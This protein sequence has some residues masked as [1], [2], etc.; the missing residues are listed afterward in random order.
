MF[1][2]DHQAQ[3]ERQYYVLVSGTFESHSADKTDHLHGQ[4][5]GSPPLDIRKFLVCVHTSPREPCN[6]TWSQVGRIVVNHEKIPSAGSELGEGDPWKGT[7]QLTSQIEMGQSTLSVDTQSGSF[8]GHSPTPKM[9][10]GSASSPICEQECRQ[11]PTSRP[12]STELPTEVSV[13]RLSSSIPRT[14]DHPQPDAEHRGHSPTSSPRSSSSEL[15]SPQV[16]SF[17]RVEPDA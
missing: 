10:Q 16:S 5:D 13:C 12:S 7:L 9:P 3:D 17:S 1:P 11:P 6:S 8:S 15:P 2:Q 4:L 14:K